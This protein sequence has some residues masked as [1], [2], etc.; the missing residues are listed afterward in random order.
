ML[1]CDVVRFLPFAPQQADWAHRCGGVLIFKGEDGLVAI[2]DEA[3]RLR[4]LLNE[5]NIT[6]VDSIRRVTVDPERGVL[7]FVESFSQ[8]GVIGERVCEATLHSEVPCE[9]E[10]RGPDFRLLQS[11]PL[12][13]SQDKSQTSIELFDAS[14]KLICENK[15]KPNS[16]KVFD[17]VSRKYW[18]YDNQHRAEQVKFVDAKGYTLLVAKFA[19]TAERLA[20]YRAVVFDSDWNETSSK[21]LHCKEE[22]SVEW[23]TT[24]NL[25]VWIVFSD[26]QLVIFDMRDKSSAGIVCKKLLSEIP[27]KIEVAF[28]TNQVLLAMQSSLLV[29]NQ[30][31]Q[32]RYR[33]QIDEEFTKYDFSL[34]EGSDQCVILLQSRAKDPL[35]KLQQKSDERPSFRLYRLTLA[36]RDFK[37]Q[38]LFFQPAG[39]V[40]NPVLRLP[41]M[42]GG[43]FIQD[44]SGCINQILPIDM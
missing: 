37:L 9:A 25:F 3:G 28:K 6:S 22:V 26:R 35:S 15:A 39:F 44:Q 14:H 10:N 30:N 38:E 12:I 31:G 42:S 40:Q 7:W 13:S 16:F 27:S 32:E 34:I 29:F 21:K 24:V 23:I 1:A 11:K 5:G 20:L 33:K 43:I 18:R 8:K 41:S 17:L 36:E 2:M 4:G 19:A